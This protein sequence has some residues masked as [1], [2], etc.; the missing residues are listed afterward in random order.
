[1]GEVYRA[2]DAKLNRD[3]AL[4]ILSGAFV[5]DP[6]RLARFHREAQVLASLNHPNIAAI[7]GFED[8]AATHALVLELVEG[9]TLADRIAQGPLALAD[10]LP[11]ARQLA[12]A[13]EAAHDL[14]IVHRDLKPA[15]IKV[16]PDG[17]VKVLDF[18]LAKALGPE[19]ASASADAMNSPTL[20]RAT[21]LGVILGTAAYMS[22]EQAKG[23]VVDKRT[24]IWAFGCVLYEMLS[25]RRAFTG[26][27]TSDMLAAVLRQEID[28]TALPADTPASLKRL[29]A[30]CLDRDSRTR[31]RDI[32]EVRVLLS[33]PLSD[34]AAATI[35]PRAARTSRGR[36]AFMWAAAGLVVGAGI[37]VAAQWIARGSSSA[38]VADRAQEFAFQRLTNLPGPE[39]HP[40]ISPDGRHVLYT[41]RAAGNSDIYLLRVGGARAINLTANSMDD[42]EQ[43]RFSPTGDQIVFTSSRDGGG[44]FLMGATG[45]SVKRLTTT[46]YDPAWS[47]DGRRI[48]YST[49]G[50]FDPYMRSIF[51]ELWTVEVA[52]GTTSRVYVGDAVQPAW[53]PDGSRIAYWANTGGQRDIWTI[54]AGGGKPAAVTNDAATDWSPIW[55]PD[56]Q[57]LYFTSDRGGSMNLWRVRIDQPTGRAVATPQPVTNSVRAIGSA[58]LSASGTK[59]IAMGYDATTDITVLS[60]DASAPDRITPRATIRN[61]AF[62][63]CD[64]SPDGVWLACTHRGAHEDL[65]LLRSDG[66]ETRRLMDDGFKDR[67]ALWSPDGKTISFYS[68]RGGKWETWAIQ[69]DGS[70]L[71]QLTNIDKDTGWMVWSP[72]GKSGIVSSISTRTVWRVD[73]SRLNSLPSAEMMKDVADA[74]LLDV[75]SWAPS[76]T[77]ISGSYYPDPMTAVPA[78][79]DFGAK[80]LR[81]LHLPVPASSSFTA[82]LPDSRRLLVSSAGALMLVDLAGGP[83]R[84]LRAGAP[85][86]L[87]RLSRDGRTLVIEHPVFDSD[88]WLME[89]G[90]TRR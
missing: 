21:Q 39:R 17:T 89:L 75:Q 70:N 8:S 22:P 5:T 64:P 60:F 32:G 53:S 51:A 85:G 3:V 35:A 45:E 34:P 7:Y 14:G 83:T 57:W 24:D 66:S 76:G 37:V 79:W 69:A 81:K 65:V 6:D 19:S 43:A 56:G 46:G 62:D 68:T 36:S 28:W 82:F 12:D 13:L 31:L 1:M 87:Y 77:L 42:D 71:R 38:G 47:P 2:R 18:G 52:A 59:M 4:K 29:L 67:G 48:A 26:D 49:E 10:A 9:P 11:M 27:D 63:M 16:R 40:D 25:G 58:R 54:P 86:D 72:D 88:I 78:V 61:Q 55:S 15:N 30:R 44:L 23:K 90:E 20:T 84:Q 74:G 41:S 73:S 80:T 33:S 50:V